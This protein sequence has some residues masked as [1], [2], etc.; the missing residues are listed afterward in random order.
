MAIYGPTVLG[1]PDNVPQLMTALVA[2]FLPIALAWTSAYLLYRAQQLRNVSEA[3][4]HTAVRLVRPQD[5]AADS[6]SSVAQT[7]REEVNLLVSG[8]DSAAQRAGRA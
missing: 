7:I 1:Q 2:M 8:V 5:I 6:L 3:L 4:M